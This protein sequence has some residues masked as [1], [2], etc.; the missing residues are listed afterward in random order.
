MLQPRLRRAGADH[1][2]SGACARVY[3]VACEKLIPMLGMSEVL[4][5]DLIW[6]ARN[7]DR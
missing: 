1:L 5:F 6:P 3:N 7:S 4:T 2:I